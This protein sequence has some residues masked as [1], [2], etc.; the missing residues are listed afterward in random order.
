MLLGYKAK[1]VVITVLIILLGMSVGYLRFQVIKKEQSEHLGDVLELIEQNLEKTIKD[2]YSA[3]L[4]LA[5]TVNPEG[6]VEDFEEI[7]SK[8]VHNSSHVDVVQLVPGGTIEYVYPLQGNESVIGYDILSDPKVNAEVLKVSEVGSIYFAG[9][10]ELKQGGLAV[11][12]RLPVNIRGE[13]W[14]YSAV[15]IYF[16]TLIEQSGINNFSEDEYY[17]QLT[18]VN[19]NTSEV[20]EFLPVRKDID[21]TAFESIEFPEGDWKLHGA[22]LDQGEPIH[23]FLSISVF[24]SIIGIVIGFLS[25]KIFKK[26][27]ELQELLSEKTAQLTKTKEDYKKNSEL[28]LSV[29]ESPENLILLSLDTEY[30]YMAFNEPHKKVMKSLWGADIKKGDCILDVIPPGELKDEIKSNYDR[31]LKGESFDDVRVFDETIAKG[32]SWENRYSPIKSEDGS[33]IGITVFSINVTAQKQAERGLKRSE[34]RYK[35]LI[36]NSPFCI[37]ELSVDRKIISMNNAGLKMMGAKSEDEFIGETYGEKAQPEQRKEIEKLFKDTLNGKFTEFE[38]TTPNGGYFSSS[39]VPIFDEN[40]IVEKVMGITQDITD[41]KKNEQLIEKSLHE[42]TTLLSEIHHRVKNNLAIVSGL[43]QLQKKDFPDA[44][45]SSLLDESIN[46]I[47]SI[48]MVHELMYKSPDL[49]SVSIQ[50]YLEMIIPAITSSMED[51]SKDISFNINIADYKLNINEAIPLGLLLNELITNS[52]KYAFE[53]R[54]AGSIDINLS[55]EQGDV[56][57]IYQ[58][59]GVGFNS[60]VDFERPV[61]MGLTLIHAQLTQLEATHTAKTHEGF[62]LEFS[63]TP[64]R[65]NAVENS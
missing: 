33:I 10:L 8:L 30:R 60:S 17:F 61:N 57:V 47:T 39:F 14:G 65:L 18:K 26:P 2:S 53:D 24:F 58:D 62:K 22:I 16:E 36:S 20:E 59:D 64:Q 9:P 27:E 11:I 43:L 49:S 31:V 52:F 3:A 25:T 4:T 28:L 55:I 29:L 41:R 63:F 44:E 34:K 38:F 42:K 23:A 32:L 21:L 15:I 51:H 56:N 1:G 7:A 37:H 46:R 13:I 5:L 12:G 50:K 45:V 40:G 35:A 6:E 19:P 54:D 48:A